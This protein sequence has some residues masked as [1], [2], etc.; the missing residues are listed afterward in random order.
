MSGA[1]D[2][3]GTKP[4]AFHRACRAAGR[5][6]MSLLLVVAVACTSGEASG[7]KESS[8]LPR[9]A[10]FEVATD[11]MVPT[12][13]RGDIIAVDTRAY[14]SQP[15]QRADVVAFQTEVGVRIGRV[16]GLG[17]ETVM[18]ADGHT[19]VDGSPV[20]EP[21]LA[22]GAGRGGV[23]QVPSGSLFVMGDNRSDSDDSRFQLGPIDSAEVLGR[24]TK[25][26]ATPQSAE[27]L[28]IL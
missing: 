10:L 8:A 2:H 3:G 28:Q 12:F 4:T 26:P 15:V 7:P 25:F 6:L 14:E 18:V 23:W 9:N 16:V 13:R 19:L 21:Y 22:S 20:E 24:V 5:P 27:N 1:T 17:G 11:S